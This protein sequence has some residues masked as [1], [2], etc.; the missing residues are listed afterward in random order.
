VLDAELAP[1]LAQIHADDVGAVFGDLDGVVART[2]VEIEH[3]L[4]A[5]A[6]PDPRTKPE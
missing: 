4:V 3:V 1:P 5:R 6:I 2:A